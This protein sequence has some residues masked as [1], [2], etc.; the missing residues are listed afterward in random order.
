MAKVRRDTKGRIL[1]K[2]E[3]YRKDTHLYCYSYT[4]PFG[5]RK[6]FYAKDLP[7]LREKEEKMIKDRLDGL[8]VYLL[9][10]STINFVFDRYI[11]NKKE[12]RESTKFSYIYT[13]D[14][15]IR[16]GFGKRK[17]ADIRYSDVLGF[18]NS[19]LERG[20]GISTID[21]VHG[22][23]HPTFQLAIR[24]KI[25]NNNP[26]DGVMAEFKKINFKIVKGRL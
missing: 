5:E 13:Y 2:G 4:T 3:I 16:N 26:S 14:S 12:I 9:G 10:K 22:V 25:I 15:Y 6:C 18:Y 11:E 19:L 17:I 7:E 23:L 20:L 1:H 8:D 24:D 21:N